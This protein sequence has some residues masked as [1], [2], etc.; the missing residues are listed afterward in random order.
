M[1]ACESREIK[2]LSYSKVRE[3]IKDLH[4]RRL[5]NY[6]PEKGISIVGASVE[7]LSRV[8]HT[9]ERRKEFEEEET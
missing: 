3:Y 5:L 7:D 4:F 1:I 2:P 9:I 8:L 6:N